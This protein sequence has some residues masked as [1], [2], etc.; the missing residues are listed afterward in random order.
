M[1]TVAIVDDDLNIRN[2]LC[3]FLENSEF[4]FIGEKSGSGFI[5]LLKSYK[6]QIDILIL[7]VII[8]DLITLKKFFQNIPN[9]D[10]NVVMITGYNF[11]KNL[12]RELQVVGGNK[13]FDLLRK[14]FS[15]HVFLE[16]LRKYE[17]SDLETNGVL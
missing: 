7:D 3:N 15:K 4:K 16:T 5:N 13:N 14:P 2:L 8:P 11:N 12:I 9:I 10:I 6:G 1:K 17:S